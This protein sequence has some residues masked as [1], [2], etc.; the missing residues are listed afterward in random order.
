M[1][2]GAVC[3]EV[4]RGVGWR[5]PRVTSCTAIFQVFN[6]TAHSESCRDDVVAVHGT[7]WGPCALKSSRGQS[8]RAIL[9]PRDPPRRST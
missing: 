6:T 5:K 2:V 1:G 7:A 4:Y 3:W 8:P 9:S